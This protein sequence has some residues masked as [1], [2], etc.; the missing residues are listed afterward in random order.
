MTGVSIHAHFYQPPR[1]DP[2][3]GTMPHEF[4]AEPYGNW[5][6]KIAEECY[7]PN[8]ERG[9]FEGISF[10][11]GPTLLAWLSAELPEVHA[12]LVASEGIYR[13]RHGTGNGMAQPY[14]H[15]I[16]PLATRAEKELQVAWGIADFEHRFGHR[17]RG[18]W[19]PET[20]ADL[21]TLD[22]LAQQGIE[23]TI[24][25][26]WQA[27]SRRVDPTRPY[28]VRLPRRRKIAVFFFVASVSGR[29]SFDP[30]VSVDADAFARYHLT[31]LARRLERAGEEDGLLLVATDGELYG[32]HQKFRDLFLE[33]LLAGAIEDAGMEL[34]TPALYLDRHPPDDTVDLALPS[35]WSCHHGVARWQRECPCTPGA[36]WKQPLRAALGE[37]ARG[38]DEAFFVAASGFVDDPEALLRRYVEVVLGR[39]ELAELAAQIGGKRLGRVRLAKLQRLLAAQ[40]QRHRIFT[41]CGW[42]WS[43]LD[44]IEPVNNLVAAAVAYEWTQAATGRDPAPGIREAL[45]PAR[46]RSTGRS[47]AEI[48]DAELARLGGKPLAG[49]ALRA[50]SRRSRSRVRD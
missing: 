50:T 38:L 12:R 46:S 48:F 4:G 35:A 2:A 47:A 30:S 43:E 5:N 17:P 37:L 10:D 13:Q 19:L 34:T 21:E 20:A 31:P 1:D 28:W 7:R 22:V 16:L 6:Q 45:A 25:A 14:H 29:L 18:M 32:H 42:F 23:F 11:A 41:S 15:T 33:R 44:R 49:S 8:A 26:P 36:D 9:N 40:W 27:A 39:L 3:T 24:L